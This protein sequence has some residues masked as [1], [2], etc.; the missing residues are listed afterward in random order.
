MGSCC[1]INHE[2]NFEFKNNYESSDTEPNT[3]RITSLAKSELKLEQILYEIS[4]E[5]IELSKIINKLKYLYKEKI[6]VFTEIELINLAIYSRDDNENNNFLIFDMRISSEQKE[7]YL[8]KIKHINYT[9]DQ[10]RN[11]KKIKK[12]EILQNFIDNKDIIIITAKKYLSPQYKKEKNEDNDYT[13]EICNLLYLI[14][15]N[16]NFKLLNSCLDRP[17]EKKD[18]FVDYLSLYYS[19]NFLPYILF[20]YKHLTTLYK[21]G[22]FYLNF[23]KEQIFYIENYIKFL[24]NINDSELKDKYINRLNEEN[25]KYQ[26]LNDM[27]VTMII[28]ID[29][30]SKNDFEIKE[31]Q[32]QRQIYKEIFLNKNDLNKEKKKINEFISSIKKEIIKGHSVYIDVINYEL[33]YLE[34]ENQENNWIFIIVFLILFITEVEY[35]EVINYLKEKMIYFDNANFAIDD[36]VK[37]EEIKEIIIN[38]KNL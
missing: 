3:N 34:N 17:E 10:I 4:E 1:T 14:N 2:S 31:Y 33:N 16:I 9:F 26:F 7:N 24:E 12:F 37:K 11:I 35:F 21:E 20:T 38:Y 19:S 30:E 23:S 6:K 29:N 36:N 15:D 13:I 28:N 18:K 27:N 8:K 25:V 22:Y 32:H 5:D